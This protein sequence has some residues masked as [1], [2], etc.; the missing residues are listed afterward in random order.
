MARGRFEKRKPAGSFSWRPVIWVLMLMTVLALL[1]GNCDSGQM[2]D[3]TE[4]PTES[5]AA[6]VIP[7]PTGQ[8][9]PTTEPTAEPTEEPTEEPT[10][11]P[12]E[13][14]T[15]EPTTAPTEE[16]TEEPTS[17]P[18]EE[19][20]EEPTTAPTEEPTEEPTTE[21]TEEPSTEP[22]VYIVPWSAAG[23]KA[24]ATALDRVGTAYEFGASGPD[25][26]DTTGLVFY[27]FREHGVMVPREMM[28]QASYGKS[29][30][31]DQLQPG[32]VLF[33][34]TSIPGEIEYVGIY[35][36]NRQFVAARNPEKP[37][38]I[39]N[40]DSEY[41]SERYLFARRYYE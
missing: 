16:P 15:E 26:F 10:T 28:E 2:P 4:E 40:L 20:T 13:E 6:P 31:E 7:E 24:A 29:V 14:P 32:D 37:T 17:A 30:P 41:F 21:P 12:T 22:T 11:A 39:M 25:T 9:V 3:L 18:T 34:W 35:I 36:G 38:S 27:C 1:M 8:T 19:P 5:T 23:D 33:F